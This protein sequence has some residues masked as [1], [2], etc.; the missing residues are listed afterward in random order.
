MYLVVSATL[1]Q[2]GLSHR[3]RA[4]DLGEGEVPGQASHEVKVWSPGRVKSP[5][6]C[7]PA[8]DGNCSL[9][10]GGKQE[11]SGREFYHGSFLQLGTLFWV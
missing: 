8:A 2:N 4:E 3:W 1:W 7:G 10:L 11:V 6:Q 9:S 5:A